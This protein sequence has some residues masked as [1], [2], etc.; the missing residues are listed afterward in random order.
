[1]GKL[2]EK[3][4]EVQADAT[5]LLLLRVHP[6]ELLALM[7]KYL[8]NKVNHLL[9]TISITSVHL[10]PQFNVILKSTLESFMDIQL[11]QVMLPIDSG[12][13]GFAAS[14]FVAA[15]PGI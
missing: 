15:Y 5:K 14:F 12:G 3:L 13:L 7:R 11:Q 4:A 1:V 10:V 9:R 8:N 6:Q 2:Q